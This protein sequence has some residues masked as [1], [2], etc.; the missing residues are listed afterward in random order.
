MNFLIET[1][2][3]YS[4]LFCHFVLFLF[5]L[6]IQIIVW[7]EQYGADLTTFD[8]RTILQI[9]VQENLMELV[10]VSCCILKY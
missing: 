4:F 2:N 6:V 9:S 8:H 1:F 5:V 3:M 7:M 10:E